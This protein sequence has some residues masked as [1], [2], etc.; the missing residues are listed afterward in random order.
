[1]CHLAQACHHI[2][3]HAPPPSIIHY[4]HSGTYEGM[5]VAGVVLGLLRDRFRWQQPAFA[6]TSP[7][8]K[9]CEVFTTE[10]HNAFEDTVSP[11]RTGPE[12]TWIR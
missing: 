4:A 3:L 12:A 11:L 2:L 5:K 10:K 6:L 1:M 8:Q 7:F 9:S